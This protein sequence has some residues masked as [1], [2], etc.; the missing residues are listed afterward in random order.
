M[1]TIW[2][3]PLRI[4]DWVRLE[5][6]RGAEILCVQV[7]GLTPCLWAL[8]DDVPLASLGV[9]EKVAHKHREPLAWVHSKVGAE[10]NKDVS[11][12]HLSNSLCY[13]HMANFIPPWRTRIQEVLPVTVSAQMR[14]IV[15][16]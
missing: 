10:A 4:R 14:L 16:H 13:P 12:V 9:A 6:P 2:K 11:P 7:Q 15:H 3:Y 1:K 5:M 8:V